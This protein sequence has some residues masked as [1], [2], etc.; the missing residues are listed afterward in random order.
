M[1]TIYNYLNLELNFHLGV[2][3]LFNIGGVFCGAQARAVN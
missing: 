3:L 2:F 1:L